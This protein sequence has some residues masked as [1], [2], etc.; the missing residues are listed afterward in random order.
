MFLFLQEISDDGG[1]FLSL[2][3]ERERTRVLQY[4]GLAIGDQFSNCG[5]AGEE[6]AA[7]AVHLQSGAFDLG[8]LRLRVEG[9]QSAV[10]GPGAGA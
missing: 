3:P 1:D 6:R 7:A 9:K 10:G 8:E 4:F 2:L 5:L